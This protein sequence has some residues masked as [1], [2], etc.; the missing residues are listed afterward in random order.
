MLVPVLVLVLVLVPVP[1]RCVICL[2]YEPMTGVEDGMGRGWLQG[3]FHFVTRGNV[4]DLDLDLDLVCY[5]PRSIT[6]ITCRIL[7]C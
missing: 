5:L 4:C 2:C 1:C 3:R 7:I 6:L